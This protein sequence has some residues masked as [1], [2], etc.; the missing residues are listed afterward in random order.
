M[1]EG[2]ISLEALSGDRLYEYSQALRRP[3]DKVV[4]RL[5][6]ATWTVNHL[7]HVSLGIK[8]EVTELQKDR[9]L[10]RVE[11]THEENTLAQVRIGWMALSRVGP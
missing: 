4:L 8:V 3:A 7:A 2:D 9:F 6:G 11:R 10:Y 1:D 5:N